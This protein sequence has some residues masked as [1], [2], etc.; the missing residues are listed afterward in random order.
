MVIRRLAE[1]DVASFRTLRLR[2]VREHPAGFAVSFEEAASE[3]IESIAQS[4]YPEN[5]TRGD[6]VLGAFD[7]TLIGMVGLHRETLTKMRHKALIWGMYVQQEAQGRGV[8]RA[9]LEH[10]IAAARTQPDLDQL[11]L[12]VGSTNKAAQQLYQSLGF[13]TYGTE[14]RALRLGDQYL[15]EC[16]ML[17]RLR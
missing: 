5:Q 3:P 7:E 15:D 13:Q 2:A 11:M 4:L 9:L 10:A 12:A 6:F 14:P 17:L 16:L 8:G 1:E